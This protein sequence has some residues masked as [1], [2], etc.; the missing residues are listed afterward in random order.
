MPAPV[1]DIPS[2]QHQMSADEWQIC[3]DLAAAYRLVASVP[4]RA[5]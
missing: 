4:Q 5:Q 3:V 1:L 2:R